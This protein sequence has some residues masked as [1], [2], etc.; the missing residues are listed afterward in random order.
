MSCITPVPLGWA[1]PP[2]SFASKLYGMSLAS[3][4][5]R[6]LHI[7]D[8]MCQENAMTDRRPRKIVLPPQHGYQQRALTEIC[9][10]QMTWP[11]DRN[12]ITPVS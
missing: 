5:H 2:A 4:S 3:P 6:S 12:I 1:C 7:G 9:C 11:P 10:A 8:V